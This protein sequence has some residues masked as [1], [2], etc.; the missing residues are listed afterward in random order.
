MDDLGVPF[1]LGHL[2]V[3]SDSK[4]ISLTPEIHLLLVENKQFQP[5]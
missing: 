1:I 5:R 4:I 2:H 3:P